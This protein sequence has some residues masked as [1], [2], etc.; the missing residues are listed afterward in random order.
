MT[1]VV[2]SLSLFELEPPGPAVVIID[3]SDPAV[4]DAFESSLVSQ[5][6]T[7]RASR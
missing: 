7:A 6:L 4:V 1:S 5:V 3:V 2:L